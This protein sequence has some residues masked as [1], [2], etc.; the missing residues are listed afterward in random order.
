MVL[1]LVSVVFEEL[2]VIKQGQALPKIAPKML[3]FVCLFV[4][5]RSVKGGYVSKTLLFWSKMSNLLEFWS[6]V[7]SLNRWQLQA[8]AMGTVI[9]ILS[10][11]YHIQILIKPKITKVHLI[12]FWTV[13]KSCENQG[14][15][16]LKTCHCRYAIF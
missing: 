15:S 3:C 5:C 1:L 16:V 9:H 12:C 6:P 10:R 14:V 7:P 4:F 13:L 2:Q 11:V 8:W